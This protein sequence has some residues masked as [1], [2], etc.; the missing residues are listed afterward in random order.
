M[1]VN[2]LAIKIKQLHGDISKQMMATGDPVI[3]REMEVYLLALDKVTDLIKQAKDV[4]RLEQ[5]L[6]RKRSLLE[7]DPDAEWTRLSKSKQA[8]NSS[9]P[10]TAS[11]SVTPLSGVSH[12]EVAAGDKIAA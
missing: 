10:R 7:Q 4:A 9:A 8:K 5:Q 2:Q 11:G 12:E 3:R 6:A 1:D